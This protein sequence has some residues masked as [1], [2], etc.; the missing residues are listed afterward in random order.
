[1][2]NNTQLNI[3]DGGDKSERSRKI[4]KKIKEE[5]NNNQKDLNNINEDIVGTIKIPGTSID[6][7][8][9]QGEIMIII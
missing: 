7:Y 6:E 5:K 1:M 8:I 2:Y 4:N 9:V 3:V